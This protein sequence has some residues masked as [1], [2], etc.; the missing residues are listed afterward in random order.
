MCAGDVLVDC[1]VSGKWRVEGIVR[2]TG[3]RVGACAC[4]VQHALDG[5]FGGCVP[6]SCRRYVRTQLFGKLLFLRSVDFAYLDR[7]ATVGQRVAYS[8]RR[9]KTK[10]RR[11]IALTCKTSSKSS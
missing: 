8:Q 5:G 2:W 11:G 9:A 3:G 10:S 1:D 6:M 4:E 7:R